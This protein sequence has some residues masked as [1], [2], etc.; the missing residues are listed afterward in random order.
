M[1]PRTAFRPLVVCFHS[2]A[3]SSR[4]WQPLADRIGDAFDVVAPDLFGHGAGPAWLGDAR[5]IVDADVA[6]AARLMSVDRRAHLVGHS[7]GGVIALKLAVT[8]AR[9]GRIVSKQRISK[10][11]RALASDDY[12]SHAKPFA[13]LAQP[14]GTVEAWKDQYVV[15]GVGEVGARFT[16]GRFHWFVPFGPYSQD[17][18]GD[19]GWIVIEHEVDSAD[20]SALL[21]TEREHLDPQALVALA[22]RNARTARGADPRDIEEPRGARR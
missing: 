5:G 19:L 9:P 4:Q 18:Q 12:T 1:S 7:Y 20:P 15:A 14:V 22:V 2:S 11:R 16:L 13:V 21:W 10:A 8:D 6:R 17:V 3:S